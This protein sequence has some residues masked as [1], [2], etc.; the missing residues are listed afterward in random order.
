MTDKKLVIVSGGTKG[1]GLE[2]V[3]QLLASKYFVVCI[4]RTKPQSVIDLEVKYPQ[5]FSY[6][7]FDFVETGEIK[8]LAKSISKK[9]GRVYGL[10]NNAAVG[11][12]GVLAT[13]HE[14]EISQL[15]KVNIEA[16]ILL[17]K[18]LVRAM[19]IQQKGRVINISSII[20]STGFNG[21][22][23]YGATKAALNGFTKSLSREV[24][25]AN[26]TVNSIAPGYMETD[27]TQGLQG[28]KLAS[29][30]RRSPLGKLANVDDVAKGVL[31]LM[32]ESSN[33]IT[34]TT[35]TIDAGSTA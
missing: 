27:M 29:I 19:L 5:Y 1:L 13:M 22:A 24:G 28:E 34:G 14:S 8:K 12:D 7:V 30:K 10:V 21:L 11:H 3:K 35:L 25:K 18:Y 6:E 33:S 15:I 20:A 32:D 23:V 16:P 2:V 4:G 9:Y 26:I 31:Y 17:T